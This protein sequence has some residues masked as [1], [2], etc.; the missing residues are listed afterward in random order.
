MNTDAYQKWVDERT[1]K[2][3][4]DVEALLEPELE[5]C[6]SLPERTDLICAVIKLGT[7]YMEEVLAKSGDELTKRVI[8]ELKKR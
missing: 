8:D 6:L 7:S 3:C 4:E 1:I 5:K 2:Y